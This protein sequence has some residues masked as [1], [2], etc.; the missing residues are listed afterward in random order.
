MKSKI[1]AAAMVLGLATSAAD[2][3][4]YTFN[5]GEFNGDGSIG[6]ALIQSRMC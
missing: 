2:A 1:L 3:A 5:A 4:T 6:A